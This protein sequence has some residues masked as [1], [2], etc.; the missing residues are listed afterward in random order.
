ML[1]VCQFTK[2]FHLGGTEG[3]VLELLRGLGSRYRLHVGV[4]SEEGPL[5]DAVW[6]L[7]HPTRSF[8]LNGAVARPNTVVQVARLATWLREQRVDLLHVHDFFSTLVAVP[9]AKLAGVKVVVGR[10]DLAH[11]HGPAQRRVLA[12]LTRSADAVVVNADAIRRQL[13]QED[14]VPA[15]HV[16]VIHNGLDLRRF[17]SRAEEGL[18]SPL[19]DTG[20]HPV[21]V[22]VA[23]MNHPVKRQED[24]LVALSQLNRSG[25]RLHAFL[26]GD[27]P[28]RAAL[29]RLAQALGVAGE[30]HF[31]GHR[32]DVPAIWR[33]ACAGVLCST[34]E[35]LSNAL[36][37]GMASGVPM[38]ATNVG[39]N[40][41]LVVDGER[42]LL[43]EPCRPPELVVAFRRLLAEPTWARRMG[44]AGRRFVEQSLSLERMAAAHDWLYRC[45]L[46]D[47]E[48]ENRAAP[49]FANAAPALA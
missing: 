11:W 31:L 32:L 5:M 21:V 6:R 4:L 36:I 7:G 44:Q 40:P 19:P 38:V 20:G 45:V 43:V 3:Q 8:P 18:L 35:G 26:V 49:S 25:T 48:L 2:S 42:G 28:R 47:T 10:L 15:G 13:V 34:A 23:N 46:H 9:A 37:E 39:G 33:R 12:T 29:Q 1:R 27:G 14:G 30:A 16:Y 24:L 22:H 17:D 41:D